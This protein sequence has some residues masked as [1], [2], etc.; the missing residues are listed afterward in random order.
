MKNDILEIHL[1]TIRT[2]N[3]KIILFVYA[4]EVKLYGIQRK[5]D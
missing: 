3:K 1:E 2:W 4:E 5:S